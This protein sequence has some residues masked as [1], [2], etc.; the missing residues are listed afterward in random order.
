MEDLDWYKE[1]ELVRCMEEDDEEYD[2]KDVM[3]MLGALSAVE[4]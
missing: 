3:F 4:A 1:E 2:S